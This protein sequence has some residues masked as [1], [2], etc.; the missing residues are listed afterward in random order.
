MNVFSH[1]NN[2][3]S[4]II[5]FSQ[6][7]R[8]PIK[9]LKDPLMQNLNL[10]EFLK[11]MHASAKQLIQPLKCCETTFKMQKLLL[12]FFRQRARA[13]CDYGIFFTELG[14]SKNGIPP[15][16]SIA[17][18]EHL[19]KMPNEEGIYFTPEIA[20]LQSE[21]K[22]ITLR[23]KEEADKLLSL[24]D[25]PYIPWS[26]ATDGCCMRADV[27]AQILLFSSIN[28]KQIF[29]QYVFGDFYY[30]GNNWGYHVAVG[31][32]LENGEIRILDPS[33]DRVSS[34][35]LEEWIS[36]IKP[37]YET[38][39]L[40][41][42][43]NKSRPDI[44]KVTHFKSGINTHQKYDRFTGKINIVPLDAWSR[45]FYMMYLAKCKMREIVQDY[46]IIGECLSHGLPPTVEEQ[47][48]D[49]L[50]RS[51]FR[52]LKKLIGF[53]PPDSLLLTVEDISAFAPEYHSPQ[54]N[55][56]AEKQLLNYRDYI[57]SLSLKDTTNKSLIAVI[58]SK[59][60]E[61]QNHFT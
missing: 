30:Q 7:L 54:E 32:E 33:L 28:P 24:I 19:S 14:D 53:C 52:T 21:Q 59:I 56:N 35:S 37:G 20:A 40:V 60:E 27:A 10:I 29:K 57:S 23:T 42:G 46:P 5:P 39:M 58:N 45:E 3:K 55:M 48:R 22:K 1:G 50:E 34:L 47:D 51:S 11:W 25:D 2:P 4:S 49:L 12:S 13:D 26:V 16:Y 43:E 44:E 8:L 36:Y 6:E 15:L 41:E 38:S 18:T 9:L 61:I 31:I 17:T